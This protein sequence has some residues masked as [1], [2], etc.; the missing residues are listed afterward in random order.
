MVHLTGKQIANY[1][2]DCLGYDE[3]MIEELKDTYGN[4]LKGVLSSK[5]EADCLNYYV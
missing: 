5:E 1:L 4:G 2:M 3:L